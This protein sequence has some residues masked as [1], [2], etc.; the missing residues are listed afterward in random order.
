MEKQFRPG[1]LVA[2]APLGPNGYVYKVQVGKV[3]WTSDDGRVYVYYHA[4]G[5]AASTPVEHLYH[6]ENDQYISI[7]DIFNSLD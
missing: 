1:Q 5:T 2:Y 7:D 4:G 3:K 6:I